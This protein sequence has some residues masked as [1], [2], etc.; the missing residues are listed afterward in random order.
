MPEKGTAGSF[1]KN[2]CLNCY[3]ILLNHLAEKSYYSLRVKQL[4]M[5]MNE[6]KTECVVLPSVRSTLGHISKKIIKKRKRK[7]RRKK[8]RGKKKED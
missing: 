6:T 7:K 4:L 3:V 5:F 2:S 8:D 1:K